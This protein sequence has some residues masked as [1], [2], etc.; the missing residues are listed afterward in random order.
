[1]NHAPALL[2]GTLFP[3]IPGI[4]AVSFRTADL[5]AQRSRLLN[6]GFAFSEAI[7]RLVVPAEQASG[8]AVMFEE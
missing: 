4:A 5:A 6:H 7:G 1:M 3:P 2:P 8:V